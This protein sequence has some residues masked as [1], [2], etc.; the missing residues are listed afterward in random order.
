[1]IKNLLWD[2][3]GT[4][5]DTYP[6][7]NKAIARSLIDQGITPE[8]DLIDSLA[9]KSMDLCFETLSDRYSLKIETLLQHFRTRYAF[10]K[11]EEQPAFPDVA[12]VCQRIYS[13][14]GKNVAVTHRNP[15]STTVLLSAHGLQ[16]FF[17]GI[18]STSQGFARKP[19]PDLI[20]A[21]L[22]Q[23]NLDP[24]ETMMIGDREIDIQS[25]RSACVLTCLHGNNPLNEPADLEIKSY[26]M[27]LDW[28]INP[29]Q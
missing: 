9:R 2:V 24:L 27:L 18:V 8:P 3:D 20:L 19:S 22:D 12:E 26:K 7:I 4:L 11:P 25:G 13:R 28:L 16:E 15:E 29:L 1:M 5:F 23:F 6:A 14:G 21:A 17:A 10:T